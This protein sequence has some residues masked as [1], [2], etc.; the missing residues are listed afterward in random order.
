M[1]T[2]SFWALMLGLALGCS[3]RTVERSVGVGDEVSLS[4]K[5]A[6]VVIAPHAPEAVR[7]AA[8]EMTNF[9][10]RVFGR[11]VPVVMAPTS[12]K[13]PV[14]LG[15]NAWNDAAGVTTNGLARDAFR[16][17]ISK[18][19]VRI[20]GIDEP[21][22]AA[23]SA[24]APGTDMP[25]GFSETERATLFGVYEFLERYAG[26]RMYFPGELGEV[27]PR[28]DALQLPVTEFSRA[29]E[30]TVRNVYM[31]GDG[32]WYEPEGTDPLTKKSARK[33]LSWARLRLQT[34]YIPCCHGQ[35]R[36]GFL[37]RFGKTHPEYFALLKGQDGALHR[38]CEPMMR[39]NYKSPSYYYLCQ[40]SGM[41]DALYDDA[42][43]YFRDND[44][45][46]GRYGHVRGGKYIDVMCEDGFRPCQCEACKAAYD[47]TQP[48][49]QYAT[50]L[51][52][53]QTIRLANRLK[54]SGVS[55]YVTQMAYP[56]YHN[57]PKA[58]IPDNLLV[59]VAELGPWSN[60]RPDKRAKDDAEI[61]AW[62]EK[63]GRKVWIWTY[64]TKWGGLK[65]PGVP[66]MTPK[67]IGSYY[68]EVAPYIFGAFAES[69]SDKAI[70]Q[71]LNY[72]VFSKVCW[73]T[74]TD[75]DALLDEH[76]RL[77]FGA[78]APEM[79]EFY[80]SLEDKWINRIM[81]NTVDTPVGPVTVPPNDR[82]L[83]LDIY[84]TKVLAGY[85]A[86]FSRALKKVPADSLEA[87]RLKFFL[88]EFVDPLRP[89]ADLVSVERELKR[90][91]GRP[92]RSV[93][94]N[95]EFDSLENWKLETP[96]GKGRMEI[97]RK[98]FVTDGSSLKVVMSNHVSVVQSIPGRIVPGKRYRL[99]YF[100]K[101]KDMVPLNKN[102][103]VSMEF[104]NGQWQFFPRGGTNLG[105]S[106][107]FHRCYEFVA[108]DLPKEPAKEQIFRIFFT[109]CRGTFWIDGLRV[110]E[111]E[112]ET[113]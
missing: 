110:E 94:D 41:W 89:K 81:A 79:K 27:V 16:V 38:D 22:G 49:G 70:Y 35:C 28:R 51:I 8:C 44:R 83:W 61:R 39:Q 99:S 29:P 42:V 63:C 1:R 6:E 20:V 87:K 100:L 11:P 78:A 43:R 113:K 45:K 31:Q 77:M 4:C 36:N 69:G 21:S 48:G 3:E 15:A 50:E 68:P 64:I 93:I 96:H 67:A 9:L 85:D 24:K 90:R 7:F 75:V 80:E 59:M 12:G 72:Y 86:L 111:I 53:S 91:A 34:E 37:E 54:K 98:T 104:Y 56:P 102:G 47:D 71:Y 107:W 66:Q 13:L 103:Q 109:N 5:N 62:A 46:I 26:V 84:S 2:N 14:F 17:W 10:S 65:M 95:G 52:W 23:V 57:L 105:T 76:Y 88:R 32:A 33:A 112:G 40:S 19:A 101:T 30:F 55:G 82:E 58:D 108:Q 18:D 60:G 73:D 92:N 97:D 106:D 25:V 74:K